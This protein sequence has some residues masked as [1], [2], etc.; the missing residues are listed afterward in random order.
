MVKSMISPNQYDMDAT[1]ENGMT[2]LHYASMKANTDSASALLK[3]GANVNCISANSGDT[4]LHLACRSGLL[5]MVTENSTADGTSIAN[6]ASNVCRLVYCCI[7]G[8]I[9]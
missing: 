7:M 6:K 8:R 2:Q 9:R 4:P 5:D 3:R 1:D